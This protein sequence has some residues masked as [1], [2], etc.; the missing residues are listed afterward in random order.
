VVVWITARKSPCTAKN[1]SIPKFQFLVVK[2]EYSSSASQGQDRIVAL[3]F[4][5]L[6]VPGIVIARITL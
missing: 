6:A 1:E 4:F 2:F 3:Y 5:F